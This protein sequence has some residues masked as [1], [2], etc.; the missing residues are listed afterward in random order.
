MSCRVKVLTFVVVKAECL[1]PK[2]NCEPFIYPETDVI[3][4]SVS[5]I[6]SLVVKMVITYACPGFPW[7]FLW[8]AAPV[9]KITCC[10]A[11][12]IT[13]TPRL[14]SAQN[15]LPSFRFPCLRR[16][17][18]GISV[19][20]LTS[21]NPTTTGSLCMCRIFLYPENNYDSQ[22]YFYVLDSTPVSAVVF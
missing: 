13:S 2:L 10:K 7:F 18:N 8:S 11:S 6:T 5:S 3:L 15:Q 1:R 17:K 21:E 4:T 14:N 20:M 9:W 19:T 22:K 12:G 16:K